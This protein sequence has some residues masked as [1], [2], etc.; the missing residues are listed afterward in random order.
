MPKNIFMTLA[1]ISTSLGIWIFAVIV[2]VQM[3]SRRNKTVDDIAK[4]KYPMLFYPYSN[5]IALLA[6]TA[7]AFLLFREK[8]TRMSMISLIWLF[9]IYLVYKLF[10]EKRKNNSLK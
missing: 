8:A 9:I 2:V 5:Y 1:G 3:Y 4:L 10:V 7:T 6:L